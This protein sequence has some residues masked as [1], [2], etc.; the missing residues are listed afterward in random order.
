MTSQSRCSLSVSFL[1]AFIGTS[2][3]RLT[4]FCGV[5]DDDVCSGARCR[6]VVS[7]DSAPSSAVGESSPFGFD[8]NRLFSH[9]LALITPSGAPPF[10]PP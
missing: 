7:G 4:G 5:A 6:G 3:K 10:R 8:G 1:L 9:V 2:G